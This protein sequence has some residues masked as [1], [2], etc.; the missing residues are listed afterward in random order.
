VVWLAR[1][2]FA[3]KG[4]VY[5]AIGFLALQVVLGWGGRMTG[6]EGVITS[7]G[8]RPFGPALLL[9]A[10]VGLFGYALWRLVEAWVDTDGKGSDLKGI[11]SRLGF[12][13]SGVAYALLG[14]EAVRLFMGWQSGG[15]D[16]AKDW[17]GWLMR[18][19]FGR[20]LVGAVG[21]VAIGVALYQFY[22]AYTTKF[23]EDLM[24]HEMS[25]KEIT[26]AE[27]VGRMGYAARGVVYAIIG[28]FFIV[29][30]VQID[31]DEAIGVGEALQKLA[32]QPYGLWLLGTVALGFIAYGCF[33]F[34]LARYR[35][36][37]LG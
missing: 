31:P 12:A 6:S 18:Q 11:A 4:V 10:A 19:P 23:R 26:W 3:V 8:R 28:S 1:F 22:Q 15:K 16:P 7:L 21:L 35:R 20:W 27:R 34:V 33:A 5:L 29:A 32:E 25:E 30:A 37:F 24:L 36:I 9:A 2:G 13:G 17:T 14:A